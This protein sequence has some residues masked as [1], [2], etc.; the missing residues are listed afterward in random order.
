[1]VWAIAEGRNAAQAMH[2]YLV[3]AESFVAGHA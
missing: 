1:V 3:N 2:R